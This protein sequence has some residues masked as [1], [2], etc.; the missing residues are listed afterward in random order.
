MVFVGRI[1]FLV[2]LREEN[3]NSRGDHLG[4]EEEKERGEGGGRTADVQR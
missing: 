1:V 3:W 2:V 4:N